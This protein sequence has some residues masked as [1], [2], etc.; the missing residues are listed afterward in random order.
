VSEFEKR[1][2]YRLSLPR[3]LVTSYSSLAAGRCNVRIRPN[4]AG[5]LHSLDSS[6]SPVN[7]VLGS[8]IY[9]VNCRLREVNMASLDCNTVWE[10]WDSRKCPRSPAE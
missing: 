8:S 7:Q 3:Y 9:L 5:I 2:K 10:A 1:F 6:T 4:F